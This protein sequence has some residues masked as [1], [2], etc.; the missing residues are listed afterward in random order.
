MLPVLE[1]DN[2]EEGVIH[3]KCID[4]YTLAGKHLNQT[5]LYRIASLKI[6]IIEQCTALM[7]IYYRALGLF[8]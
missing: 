7:F 8:F 2:T 5:T 1:G 3:N 4:K 6:L